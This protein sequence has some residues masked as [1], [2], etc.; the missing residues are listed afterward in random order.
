MT[1]DDY[2]KIGGRYLQSILFFIILLAIV[3]IIN[4]ALNISMMY[5]IEKDA[6]NRTEITQSVVI[7]VAACLRE[8]PINATEQ[9]IRRCVERRSG[10]DV[11]IKPKRNK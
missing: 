8:E 10:V 4:G 3:E 1:N 7:T 5:Q 9:D 11:P 6:K 2:R